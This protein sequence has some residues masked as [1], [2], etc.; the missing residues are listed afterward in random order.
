MKKI[1]S[2]L[3][4][5]LLVNFSSFA[6]HS[7]SSYGDRLNSSVNTIVP[8]TGNI[9]YIGGSFTTIGT[10][11]IGGIAKWNG[12]KFSKLGLKGI[13]GS[14]VVAMIKFNGGIVAA[15]NFSRIDTTACNNIGYWDG[16]KWNPMGDGLD[17]TGATT[18]STLIVYD[19]N[20][21]AAGTFSTSGN[22]T[23]SNI[24][25]WNGSSWLG[26]GSGVNGT[27]RTM[28]VYNGDLYV[29]GTF[30]T[31]GSTSVHNIARWDGSSWHDLDG[32]LEYTGATTVSTLHAFNGN[33]Y[34]GGN[35]TTAGGEIAG[36]VAAWDGIE[37]SDIGG[38]LD[39]TGATTVS[40]L[41]IHDFNGQL[42][43]EVQYRP[44][45]DTTVFLYHIQ[46]WNDT[47]WSQLDAKTNFPIHALQVVDGSL[48]AGGD[49]SQIASD[50]VFFLAQ[51]ATSSIRSML[52]AGTNTEEINGTADLY[53]N[54]VKD[55]LF[56]RST[57][58]S[59]G[60]SIIVSD[61]LGR[62]I[63]RKTSENGSFSFKDE[64]LKAGVYIYRI[65]DSSGNTVKQGK[66][67]F[68]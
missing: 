17:Y 8:D 36:P 53:P 31:A 32:G 51:W 25:K 47:A 56:F 60:Y 21:Y 22:N 63:C 20:L 23:V 26:L 9:F 11:S 16:L 27:I 29:A 41:C 57:K 58:G 34:A 43:A 2:L 64:H 66:I 15:G 42:I 1:Y 61:L 6:Q 19:S 50:S 49:F 38:G 52:F 10:D 7:W 39:Y 33:L 45:S 59:A 28:C 67:H 18:V 44:I 3:L 55:Q 30:T 68:E 5:A 46:S 35:F 12:T 37:W 4:A 62:A 48:F 54:P 24:A 13:T 65:C 40:T 14:E